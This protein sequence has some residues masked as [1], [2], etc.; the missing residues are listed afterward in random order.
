M[1]LDT[2]IVGS[3]LDAGGNVKVTLTTNPTYMGGALMFSENDPGDVTGTPFIRSPETSHDYR[4]RVGVDSIWDE[5]VFNYAAQNF[6]KHK[7]TNSTMTI[8]WAGG[9]LTTNAISSTA[10]TNTCQLQTYRHFPMQGGGG[11]YCEM[12]IALTNNPVTNSVIDFGLF[13]PGATGANTPLDGVYFRVNNTGISGV[14]NYNTA[15]QVELL[16]FT[17]TINEVYKYVIS[18]S[19]DEVEFWINDVLYAAVPKAAIA[20]ASMYTASNPFAIRQHNTGIP[21]GNISA[22]VSNYTI[23]FADMDNVRLWASNKC[24]QAMSAVNF[25]SGMAAGNTANNVLNTVPGT[26]TLTASTAPATNNLGGSFVF[27]APAGTENDFPLFAFQNPT[28][29]AAITGRNLV[30]RGVWVDTWNQVVAVATTPTIFQWSVATGST[31]ST[32]ATTD[33]AASRLPKRV[34]LGVQSYVVGAAVGYSAPRVDCNFDAPLVVEPGC[35]FHVILRVPVGTA[36]GTETF[37]GAVGVNA[38]WE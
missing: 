23:G 30:I 24:G 3:N 37:R 12:S 13:L 8:T 25:P 19:P 34:H 36:T 15:E 9:F 21:S 16:T 4:L 2:N 14:V 29:S 27:A 28:P 7:Y 35:F 1:A 11:I 5:D 6:N 32:L 10:A 20:G 33:G 22:K 38:Y 17:P 26:V 18:V 31:A